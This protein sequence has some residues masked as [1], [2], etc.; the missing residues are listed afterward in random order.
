MELSSFHK[1]TPLLTEGYVQ[2]IFQL[3][4]T[5]VSGLMLKKLAVETTEVHLR[6][7]QP[8]DYST[9]KTVAFQLH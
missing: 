6:V 9:R 4:E 3:S 1:T 5:L 2:L 7:S 8:G